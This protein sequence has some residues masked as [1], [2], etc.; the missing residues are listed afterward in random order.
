MATLEKAVRGSGSAAVVSHVLPSGWFLGFQR[1]LARAADKVSDVHLTVEADVVQGKARRPGQSRVAVR[2]RSD[3]PANMVLLGVDSNLEISR[4][5][6]VLDASVAEGLIERAA[7]RYQLA[8][9]DLGAT[10]DEAR[11]SLSKAPDDVRRLEG[12][13]QQALSR[14]RLRASGEPDEPGAEEEAGIRPSPEI[15]AKATI[16]APRSPR[17]VNTWFSGPVEPVLPLLLSMTY[18]FSLNIGPRPG[19]ETADSALFIEPDFGA[20][21]SLDV[22]VSLRSE[23]LWIAQVNHRLELP[24]FGSSTT[25]S[26]DVRPLRKGS[27]QLRVIVALAHELEVIQVVDVDVPVEAD[28][29]AAKEA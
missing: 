3:L 19:E 2:R 16:A 12:V 13:L 7:G 18:R 4:V 29:R 24:R 5:D 14:M 8:D 20:R 17:Y 10:L 6:D 9:A 23:D 26:T 11:A 22:L 1:R 27:S 25:V 28:E 21:D 15:Q